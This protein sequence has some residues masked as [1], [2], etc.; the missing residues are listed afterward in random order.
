MNDLFLST[1][2]GFDYLLDADFINAEFKTWKHTENIRYV[3]DLEK[4]IDEAFSS[5]YYKENEAV[6]APPH[7][8]GELAK[9]EAG[10]KIL[11]DSKHFC[12]MLESITD[13]LLLPLERRA[14]LWALGHVG[15]SVTGLQLLEK[16]DI[17]PKIVNL[18]EKAESLSVRGTCFYVLGLMTTTEKGQLMLEELGWQKANQRCVAVPV[19]FCSSGLLKITEQ[20]YK[21]SW[22][23]N[24]PG[25]MLID[26]PPG[27]PKNEILE[28]IGHLGNSVHVVVKR[29]VANLK[30]A[31]K[32]QPQYFH[33]H[34]LRSNV[35]K[36][37]ENYT[38]R[39][40]ERSFIYDL[41]ADTN[42]GTDFLDAFQ[43]YQGEIW[44]LERS[45]TLKFTQNCIDEPFVSLKNF[46]KERS[47]DMRYVGDDEEE[48]SYSQCKKEKEKQRTK[49][50]KE[51][52]ERKK[53][54]KKKT[55]K[56]KN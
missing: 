17:I 47:K 16:Y 29:A 36:M 2:A 28:W 35:L 26:F 1:E 33:D 25:K 27:D 4:K 13:P 56:R 51:K 10:C 45:T 44:E 38:F 5:S 22:P 55:Q 21:G 8:Y 40:V 24:S 53:R 15:S 18:V 32:E 39:P 6:N 7:L 41:I 3:Q 42:F 19:K 9:T 12:R 43:K 48:R 31:K 37:L 11:K 52:K 23:E 54:K 14:Y 49:K 20:R 46:R 50:G 30:K 34:S